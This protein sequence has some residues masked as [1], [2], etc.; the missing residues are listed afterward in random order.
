MCMGTG[1]NGIPWKY[2]THRILIEMGIMDRVLMEM[3]MGNQQ[4]WRWRHSQCIDVWLLLITDERTVFGGWGRGGRYKSV[5]LTVRLSCVPFSQCFILIGKCVCQLQIV[6]CPDLH[7]GFA[8]LP[9]WRTS[10][11]RPS[12]PTYLQS[13][14]TLLNPSTGYDL[15]VL[16]ESHAGLQHWPRCVCT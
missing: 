12:Y 1:I 5:K 15:E 14:A 7:P 13:L 16:R 8:P 2:G 9:H 3:W 11:P 6:R 10:V 4:E